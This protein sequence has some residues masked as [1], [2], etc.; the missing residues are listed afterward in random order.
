M[1]DVSFDLETLGV[2]DDAVIISI[3]AV[4]FN[5]ES[6][7]IIE[8]FYAAIDPECEIELVNASISAS[9]LKWWMTQRA[10]VLAQ[11]FEEAKNP[12]EALSE[13]FDMLSKYT[14]QGY[15]GNGA[16]FDIT[17]LGQM[18][19]RYSL[20]APWDNPTIPHSFTYVRDLRTLMGIATSL[21]F[22]KT[23][24]PRV[25][26]HHN[27]LDDAEYQANLVT[28]ATNFISTAANAA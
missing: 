4:V 24:V 11:A 25:G 27:A 22:N 13:L 18:A 21:G 9:T 23:S 3:G 19:K 2:A 5:R 7:E 12:I 10:E 16:T 15:W 26:D 17:K 20:T 14:I 1:Y 6:G 8:R 28:H